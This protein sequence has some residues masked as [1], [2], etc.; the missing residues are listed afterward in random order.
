MTI[1]E[2]LRLFKMS[3]VYRHQCEVRQVLRWRVENR[4][5]A[6]GYLNKVRQ[7]RDEAAANKLERDTRDQWAKG[8][9][10]E[11]DDWR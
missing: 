6:V 9:R 8:N 3:E 7:K 4:D 5:K 2:N 1:E 10:G 11:K